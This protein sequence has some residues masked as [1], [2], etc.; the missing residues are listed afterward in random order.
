M[1][2]SFVIWTRLLSSLDLVTGYRAAVRF[3]NPRLLPLLAALLVAAPAFALGTKPPVLSERCLT[4]T[5][6]SRAI[7]FRASDRIALRGVVLGKGSTGVAL[8]H[9]YHAD[10]CNWLP[11]A[12]AL[13]ARGYL[14]L[15]FDFRNSGSSQYAPELRVDR[16]M[17]AAARALRARGAKRVEL[18]GAS[19]GGTGALA[20][21]A[22]AH[23]ARV[24]SLS[25][26]ADFGGADAL[27]GIR[28]LR[29]PV[30]LL[31]G[32]GDTEFVPE[33]KRLYAAA[34]HATTRLSIQDDTAHGT[35]LLA[36]PAARALLLKFLTAR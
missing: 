21:G 26:P 16:D 1:R 36:R 13:A 35:A 19:M 28:K 17:V 23:A 2:T 5:E 4:K 7:S 25:G 33:A 15:A 24:A 29:V 20:A 34:P 12:R 27:V 14:V 3:A 18:A 22:V 8:G 31:V 11:F 6:R 32:S 9:E 10:L 30:L